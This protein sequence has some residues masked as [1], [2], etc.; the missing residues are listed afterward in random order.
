MALPFELAAGS[1]VG[2]KHLGSGN[3]IAGQPNQDAFSLRCTEGILV[4]TVNDG[5]SSGQNAEVG[6]CIGGDIITDCIIRAAAS[7]MLGFDDC[8]CAWENVRQ[9]ILRRLYS[10]AHAIAGTG[11]LADQRYV[12]T[13]KR[14]MQFTTLGV[15][16]TPAL[17]TVFS[18]GDGVYAVNGDLQ[19]IP[20][21]PGNAPPYLCYDLLEGFAHVRDILRFNLR[22]VV[23]T[24]EVQSVFLG[25]DGVTELLDKAERNI[26]GKRTL[27]GPLEQFWT[28]DRFFQPE[29]FDDKGRP[30]EVLTP[31]LRQANSEVVKLSVDPSTGGASL[32]RSPGLV[33]DDVTMLALRRKQE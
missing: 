12:E 6:A 7:G 10:V 28:A 22:C 18:V 14:Y 2:R 1:V 27:V 11:I 9:S 33:Q 4:G 25:T 16:V 30:L 13:V 26:P 31:W 19:V 29:L 3:L 8:S 5:C 24:D 21:Y 20:E 17:T 23:P 15:L 32:I